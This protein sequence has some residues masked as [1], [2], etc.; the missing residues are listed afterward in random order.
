M[1]FRL[2]A[3]GVLV[4]HL[5]FVLFV[6]LGGFLVLR[7]PSVAWLH[8]PAACWGAYIEFS[9]RICPLTPLENSFRERGGEAGYS[10]GFIDHYITALIYPEG[11]TRTAQMMIGTAVVVLN[12]GLY[13]WAYW[14]KRG[15]L[16]G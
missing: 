4:V 13:A 1:L 2:L 16:A 7:W 15:Q 12:V 3:D 5:A 11:L 9:G 6:A 8:V 14:K 10:G